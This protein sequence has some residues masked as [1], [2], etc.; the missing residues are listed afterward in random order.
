MAVKYKINCIRPYKWGKEIFADFIDAD[1]GRTKTMLF[2]LD[3][4]AELA[5]VEK[6]CEGLAEKIT[7]D[8]DM[9]D[10][11][12]ELLDE[13]MAE[14]KVKDKAE[15]VSVLDAEVKASG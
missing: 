9:P 7:F 14:Y 1:T 13:L 3:S 8:E 10:R 11:K 15:L 4:K 2:R 6:H 5:D 12:Q